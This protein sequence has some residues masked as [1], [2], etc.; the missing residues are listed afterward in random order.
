MLRQSL[1]IAALTLIAS[2]AL[3]AK[4][5]FFSLSNTNFV[6]TIAFLLFLQ[7]L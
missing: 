3:A 7:F 6:V 5:P 2:P 4:G 1:T